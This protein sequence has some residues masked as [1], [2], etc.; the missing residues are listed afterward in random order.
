METRRTLRVVLATVTLA[1]VPA[2]ATAG[3]EQPKVKPAL[4]EKVIKA[5]PSEARARPA[6]PRKVLVFN[7]CEGFRHGSIPLAAETFRLMGQKT[8]A[9]QAVLSEDMSAFD[10]DKLKQ[11]DAVLLNNTTRLSFGDPSHRKALLDFVKGGKGLIGIHAATDSFYKW[12]EAAEMIGAQFAGHPWHG[13]GTWAVKL[14]E[15]DHPLNKSFAGKG[16]N[17]KEEIYTFRGKYYSRCKLRVLLSLDMSDE[18][19]AARKGNRKDRDYA[20]SWIRPY[21]K[22]RVFYCSL[23][24]NE[25]LFYNSAVLG[26]YLAGI[27]YAL[28]DLKADDSPSVDF[29]AQIMGDYIGTRVTKPEESPLAA[30]VIALGKGQFLANLLPD[31]D[32]SAKPIAVLTGRQ[33]DQKVTFSAEDGLAGAIEGNKFT[34]RGPS[35]EFTLTKTT[36]PSPTLGAEPPAGATVLLGQDTKDLQAEWERMGGKP[37]GWKLLPGG[38]MQCVPG[39]GS[40][41]SKRRFRD[42]KAHIEFRIPFEPEKRGQGRGNSGVYLQGRYEVQVL[43]SYGLEGRKNECGA[44]YG[45]A[46]PLVNM[47]APPL[48]WQTYDISFHAAALD[49]EK[50]VRP[51]RITVWHNGVKIHDGVEVPGATAAAPIRKIGSEGGLYLQDHGHRVEYRNIWVRGIE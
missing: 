17:I 11:F 23:G 30:Q 51:A 38:V 4:I 42:H 28:G 5:M 33:E 1:A 44:I 24:H 19:T 15:P 48:Q 12:P 46:E 39:S 6:K 21:G 34:G 27:Q 3:A 50:V 36:R 14:G 9:F 37:C 45:I 22:G 31:F 43:D 10:A 8:G 25:E 49:G 16:F 29:A 2:T 7:R 32:K 47:C 18:A 20:I 13:R 26:H 40:V 35:H 41:I